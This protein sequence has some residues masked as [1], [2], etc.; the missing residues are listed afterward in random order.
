MIKFSVSCGISR[1]QDK[2][3]NSIK[4][5]KNEPALYLIVVHFLVNR[6][7]LCG[8]FSLLMYKKYLFETNYVTK[9]VKIVL[10]CKENFKID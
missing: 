5:R 9:S 10:L 4:T 7:G 3:P 6:S 8:P 2:N 1:L